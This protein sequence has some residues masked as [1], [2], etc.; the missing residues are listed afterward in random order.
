[1]KKLEKFTIKKLQV[2]KFLKKV[3]K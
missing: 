1:M 2:Y 3:E